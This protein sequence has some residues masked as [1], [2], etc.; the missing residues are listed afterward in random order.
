MFNFTK[1]SARE[2]LS[3]DEVESLTKS[4][5]L[6]SDDRRRRPHYFDG[7]FLAARDLTREQT[8]F[9]TRQADLG[10]AGG[11]GVVHG[12]RVQRGAG[13]TLLQI[14]PGHGITIEG[15]MIA[16]TQNLA[17]D[18][19]DVAKIQNLNRAFGLLPLPRPPA[20]VLTG[21][22]VVALRPVEFTANKT[23]AYPT[24]IAGERSTEDGDIIEGT[25]VVITSFGDGDNG[26]RVSRAQAAREIFLDQVKRPM[27]A[28]VLP[29]AI[30]SLNR[31]IVEWI[32]E[33]LVRREIGAEHADV[34]GL[35]FAPRAV[36]EAQMQQYDAHLRT[37]LQTRDSTGQG[38]R[39]SAAEVFMALP[40]AGQMPREAVDSSDFS[41]M[42][43]PAAMDVELSI[44]PEDEIPLMLEESL[45]LPPIDLTMSAEQL[46]STSAMILVPVPR[47]ELRR[48]AQELDSL[49]R[50]LRP[51]APGL[52]AR[53]KPLEVLRGFRLPAPTL[54]TINTAAVNDA[55]WQRALDQT[56]L[57]WFVRR[58]NLAYKAA[59]TGVEVPVAIDEG[60][61]ESNL[62][63]VLDNLNL[64]RRFTN[65]KRRGTIVADA[66]MVNNLAAPK[67]TNS[68]TLLEGAIREYEAEDRIDRFSTIRVS[69]RFADPSLGE[70]LTRLENLNPNLAQPSVSTAL[71]DAM[72]VPELD[73]LARKLSPTELSPVAD[74]IESLATTGT[75]QEI[76]DYVRSQGS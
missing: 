32:D 24:S 66:E 41:Q 69:T 1:G 65:L 13:P 57:L 8:Y 26:S 36:R 72:I 22:Y 71:A 17:V 16:L 60:E 48:Y 54:P 47:H 56:D 74:T 70:G 51:P 10:Q 35:G 3:R 12:L 11:F 29:L 68:L 6:L 38:R 39:F 30:V 20:R 40:P 25:A 76:A 21:L 34:L 7:R 14:T 58:R 28:G 55:V 61:T 53:L 42:F 67:F 27:P 33:F 45:L 18:V 31:G 50:P 63:D 52:V 44:V 4:G 64:R 75:P 19:T 23:N 5:A 62:Y 49:I 15:E 73:A 59:V 46:D 9:L 43:F 37:I 2:R